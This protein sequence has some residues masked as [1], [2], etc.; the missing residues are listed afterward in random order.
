MTS[1]GMVCM[2]TLWGRRRTVK[3]MWIMV[4]VG[5]AVA[6]VGGIIMTMGNSYSLGVLLVLGGLVVGVM[7]IVMQLVTSYM[8]ERSRQAHR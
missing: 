3:T 7:G 1:L 5:L 8:D 6:I 2:L 4:G